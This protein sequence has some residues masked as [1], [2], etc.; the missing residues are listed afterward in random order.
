MAS[1]NHKIPLCCF[2]MT[3]WLSPSFGGGVDAI[4]PAPDNGELAAFPK[5]EL[6][7]V[8][9]IPLSDDGDVRLS[10]GGTLREKFEYYEN[11]TFSLEDVADDGY[12]LH[13]LL[14][15]ADLQVTPY[16]RLFTEFGNSLQS[17]KQQAILS[18]LDVDSLYLHQG[19]VDGILPV[20][21]DATLT[22][23]L[24]RQEFDY[25]SG[26]LVSAREGPNVRRSFDAARFIFED[27]ALRSDFFVARPLILNSGAFDDE[28][29]EKTL[30]WGIYSV[31]DWSETHHTDIYYLGIE[32][33][34]QRYGDRQATEWRHTLGARWWGT[35]NGWDYN[36]E[37]IFQA[38]EF[39]RDLI[40][41]W[42]IASDT[43]YTFEDVMWTPRVGLKANVISGGNNLTTVTTFDALFPNNSYFSE[44]ALFAPANLFDLNPNITIFPHESL[45]FLVMWDFLW[46]YDTTDAVYV[47]P[48]V[49]GIA[50]SA[51]QSPYIGNEVSATLTW[52]ATQWT[53]VA[54]EF[55]RFQAGA[56]VREA[57]GG[58]VTYVGTSIKFSF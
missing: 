28:Q 57:G 35:E 3:V 10:F 16:F 26:R 2:W 52:E 31:W 7:V 24:G 37:A 5:N 14:I 33:E 27:N 20:D 25:G 19:F 6:L 9:D 56:F 12:L 43:G 36:T 58:D 1:L 17:G 22:M 32:R 50:G 23:R 46:R 15:N 48:G 39:D 49:P 21:R 51:G 53:T 13:R 11:L 29:D 54:V 34:E 38:G 4:S 44:A 47:P 40:L 42:S 45:S 55:T 30:F 8:K 18:P 41:A